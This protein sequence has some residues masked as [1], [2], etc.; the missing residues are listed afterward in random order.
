MSRTLVAFVKVVG[1]LARTLLPCRSTGLEHVPRSGPVIFA[2]SHQSLVDPV[3]LVA[4]L[5]RPV[6][7]LG[8]VEFLDYP[9][10]GRIFRGPLGPH[11]AVGRWEG[12]SDRNQAALDGARRLLESGGALGIYP[13]GSRAEGGGVGR[14]HTGVARLALATGAPVVPVG[15][16]GAEDM[17]AN[18]GPV[19]RRW[20]PRARCQQHFGPPVDLGEWQGRA[21]DPAAWREAT[22]AIMAAIAQL[23]GEQ[24][25]AREAPNHL[26]RRYGRRPRSPDGP[27]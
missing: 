8:K 20:R 4:A 27:G 24:Y 26:E 16:A 17:V 10:V 1:P 2:S 12:Q 11:F 15:V 5:R 9:V 19:L 22:D 6:H 23:K 13:E 18:R 7:F 3:I 25:D 14:G 21:E